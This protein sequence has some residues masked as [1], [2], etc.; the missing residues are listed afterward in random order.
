MHA[1]AVFSEKGFW[2]EGSV[3]AVLICYLFHGNPV[4]HRYIG[5]FQSLGIFEVNF[6]LAW[7]HLVMAVLHLDPHI[8]EGKYN[9]PSEIA[10]KVHGPGIKVAALVKY[11][12][13]VTVLEKEE[14]KLRPYIECVSF[15]CYLL[16]QTLEY[17]A[18]IPFVRCP[19]RVNDVTEHSCNG[20]L[21]VS[22]PGYDLEGC[23][24]GFCNHVAF[25]NPAEPL[26]G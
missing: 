4:G 16:E 13:A 7:C 8:L 2:H 14:F 23:R 9:L 11:F 18:R 17:I 19:V 20:P 5:H 3:Y 22:S 1:A 6:M 10:S 12:R 21:V 25:M 15:F 26:D 24:V